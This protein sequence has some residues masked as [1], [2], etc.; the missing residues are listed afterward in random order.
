MADTTNTINMSNTSH[1]PRTQ[2]EASRPK[3]KVISVRDPII[4]IE[5]IGDPKPHIQNLLEVEGKECVRMQ[6]LK[7]SGV[8]RFHCL[9]L[10]DIKKITREDSVVDTGTKLKIP[11]GKEML[12]RVVNV[13]GEPKDGKGEV[14][15]KETREIY[16]PAPKYS[17]IT[18]KVEI[19]ETGIKIID[20]FAPLVKG[21]K[22][23]LFGGSGVGKTVLLTEILHNII[24][25]DK[26]KNVSV[27]CGV[28]ERSREGHELY[29]EL[30]D[31]GVLDSVSLVFGSMGE[32]PS[33]RFLTA[34]AG[35]TVAEYMRDDL[36]KDVLFFMDNIFRFAQAGNEISLL[37]GNIPSEG[38][39]QPTLTSEMSSIHERLVSK[40][41][42]SITVIEAIYLPE[43]DIFDQAAQSVFGYLDS[44]IVL[45]RE[46]YRDGKLPAVDIV[47]SGSDSL[48]PGSVDSKHYYVATEAR[49]V[50]KKSELLERIVSLVGEAELSDEDRATYQRARKIKNYMT[51][52]FFVAENQT[53][54]KGV[55]VALKDNVDVVKGILEGR[56]D[57]IS[58]D[59]FLYIGGAD[60][61]KHDK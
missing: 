46:A 53:G 4:E 5:F 21:G 41:A 32:N 33:I 25:R 49:S 35:V 19:L 3:G 23:G 39:Y 38:G 1:A 59:K 2:E 57:D 13:F 11:V 31:T 47:Q 44:S 14:I 37:M 22:V 15:V 24:N 43:D 26:E 7:S 36:K 10:S 29:E 48:N 55:F 27:F 28:G 20:L 50:L 54:R 56:Y 6:V 51:Q 61:L 40:D 52:N 30:K 45:S 8:N 16:Q 9:C 17:D 18:S 60:D 58:E 34:Y 12:G 42:N